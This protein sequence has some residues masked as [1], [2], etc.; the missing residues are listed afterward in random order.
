[1]SALHAQ[2]NLLMLPYS[3][4]GETKNSNRSE[5]LRPKGAPPAATLYTIQLVHI[6]I[7]K[8]AVLRVEDERGKIYLLKEPT[9]KQ[10]A[11]L[12]KGRL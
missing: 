6:Q 9:I 1:M 12:C 4:S 11:N 5:S 2:T 7:W 3:A 8:N 10:M